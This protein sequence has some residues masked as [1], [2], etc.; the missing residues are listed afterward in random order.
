[1]VR[2][3]GHAEYSVAPLRHGR[4][5]R[6]PWLRTAQLNVVGWAALLG[7]CVAAA[8]VGVVVAR[9]LRLPGWSGAALAVVPLGAVALADRRRWA[10]METSFG[11]GGSAD[12]VARIAS[13]LEAQGIATGISADATAAEEWGEP[14]G[15]GPG[16]PM[17]HTASLSYR[18]RDAKTV[19]AMLRAHGIEPPHAPW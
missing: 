2:S 17:T 9:V 11:W 1:M 13:A 6:R 7:A 4:G 19:E 8:G 3:R 12:D 16:D 5:F 14:V 10:A 15:L 18:N